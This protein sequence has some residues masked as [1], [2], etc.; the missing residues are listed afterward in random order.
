MF[1]FLLRTIKL[2]QSYE[3]KNLTL[4]SDTTKQVLIIEQGAKSR[5]LIDLFEILLVVQV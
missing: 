3:M 2:Q 1:V 4:F 5:Q